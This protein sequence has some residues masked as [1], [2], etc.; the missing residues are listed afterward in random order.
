MDFMARALEQARQAL[1]KT[2]PNPAVG[3]LVV[4]NGAI[5]GKG[6]TQAPGQAH[7][8]VVALAQASVNAEGAVLYTTLEP[9]CHYGRTPPCTRTIVSA[10]IAE[11]HIAT[12]DPN[13]LVNG[14]GRKE[15]EEAGIRTF[16]GE[17]QAE[18]QELNEA[19]FKF[20]TTGQPFVTA[21]FAA[22]LDGK[23]ATASGESQWITGM[24]ARRRANSL[25][26][27]CDGLM[28]GVNTVL[29]DDPLLTARDEDDRPLN[30][31]PLR[32]V[33]DSRGRTPSRARLFQSPGKVLIATAVNDTALVERLLRLSAQVEAFP[34]ED[35][36][37]DLRAL[38][39]FL[40]RQHLYS[41]LAEG[42]GTLLGSLLDMQ[43]VDKVVAFI[44]PLIIGG[45]GSLTPVEG[46]GA[47]RLANALRLKRVRVEHLGD[48]L[49]IVGYP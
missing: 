5:V 10:R 32:I 49:M 45:Q 27:L 19:Y 6:H 13:P 16:V 38:L 41:I 22:S 8:E 48:D 18:A 44:A 23:I 12:L 30:V 24:E 29:R 2:S 14:Q 28:V 1:G 7:A 37:V 47:D 40:G 35:G 33:V 21:K 46:R 3:A 9:C 26:G 43:L 20:V 31:Q 25:R 36:R 11:V 17:R 34:S 39:E 4:K 15:L 42:G